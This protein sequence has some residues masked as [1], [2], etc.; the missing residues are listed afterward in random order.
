MLGP[1]VR[2]QIYKRRISLYME[3]IDC[4]RSFSTESN[5]AT[6]PSGLRRQNQDLVFRGVSSNLTVV[7]HFC[8]LAPSQVQ[9]RPCSHEKSK[10]D[11]GNEVLS[12]TTIIFINVYSDER[13][14]E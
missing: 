6:W 5:K 7:K 10:P 1:N 4:I 12:D 3:V 8:P 13:K 9:A 11:F 14:K 2:R